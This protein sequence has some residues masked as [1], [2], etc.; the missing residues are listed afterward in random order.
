M[1]ILAT[2]LYIPPP[3]PKLVHRPRLIERLNEGLHRK[4]TLISAPAG[5]G[6]T[7]LVSEWVAG[8]RRP[9]AWLS[10]DEGDNDPVRFLAYLVAAL[11]T[12]AANIGGGVLGVLQS[13]QP[14]PIESILTAL[15]NEITTVP[16]DFTLIL[17]DYHT[18]DAKP[19]DDVLTFLLE[20]LPPQMHLVIAT[21]EDPHLPLARL[22][23]RS[24]LTELR[25]TDLRFTPT[26]AA[27][28]LNQVMGL[29]L[30]AKDIAAL[31]TRTEG[32]IASLQL[33]AISMQGHKDSTSFIQSFNG[34]HHFVMDYLV[35][36]VLQQQPESIQTFLLRTS[37]LDRLCGPL[38][39]AVL[40]DPSASGQGT[41]EH[42]EHANLFIVPLD[43]E[44]RWYRYHH[45]FAD[46]LRQR[47]SQS[48]ASSTGDEGKGV[49]EYHIRASQ[50]YEDN[51]LELEAFQHA[52]AANDIDRA[53]RLVE[54]KGMPLHFRGAVAPVLHWLE[55]LPKVVLDARPSLWVMY[56]SA[57][58]MVGRLTGVEQKL[59]AAEAAL[60]GVEPDDKNLN[61]TGHIAAIRALLAA[62]Q[63]QVEAIIAQ[64]HRA[65]EYLH[66]D[67]LA[68]RTA[69]IWKLGIAYQL[70]GDRTAA[71]RAY[72][73]AISISRASGNIIINI[74]ATTG[75][76]NVQETENQLHLAAATYQR[77]LQLVGE[78]TQPAAREA[79]LGLARL[80]YQW[81]DLD[82]VQQHGQQSVQ[83]AQQIESTD[84]FVA[85]AVL[86]ARLKLAQKDVA[87]AAAI[88]AQADQLA[89]QHNFMYRM[90]DVAAAQVLTLLHQGNLTAAAHL[91]QTYELPISQAR[92]HLAQGDTSAA[93]AA[94]E[95]LR[96]QVE[97]KGWADERLKVMVLQAVAFHAHGEK[98]KAV[99]L[100]SG[101]LTLAEPSGF[102]RI[103]IDEGVP[104]ARLLSEAAAH[105]IMP[106]Y[107]GKLLA[108]FDAEEREC[109]DKSDLFPAQPLI[110]PLSQREL[111]VL[112]LI[113]Q[114]LSNREISERLFLAL[115]TVK[116]HN[117][118]IYEKLHVQRRTEAL[119]RARELGL[120]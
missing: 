114:G 108:V 49:A 99:Q 110:E 46:L 94:L 95:P 82:A 44:R 25:A 74:S 18:I 67:N 41:L 4:L 35:E 29:D 20:H 16:D 23:V 80:F 61:L 38:C 40:L 27:G 42:L 28:F 63:N 52:A 68:V 2:K 45:L 103:F 14:P 65:L 57:L 60:Q 107:I 83:L 109:E 66:P 85:S 62:A 77:V 43:N 81:N 101:A 59:Q 1:S 84:R 21:R 51:G 56:A 10:M 31:E 24:Q 48:A 39:D 8:C 93:L 64:S 33:A 69:T 5:F 9:A 53:T 70:Q 106:D 118:R 30:S 17:D 86:L 119:A 34:S 32:W 75:L 102:I 116:G 73:E 91:A 72:T 117:R 90:P 50:W 7:T 55:S 54:G 105:G 58:S 78:S 26:E 104:M 76:G 71:G 100:L 37:M 11:Q 115:D 13:S 47:L 89:R 22:R 6:K 36:E 112:Q 113:A 97:A 87:G 79:H 98:D 120:L 15:I 92:V 3:R 88:L 96:R 111:E 12:I 19:V